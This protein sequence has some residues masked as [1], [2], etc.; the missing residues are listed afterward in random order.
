MSTTFAILQGAAFQGTGLRESFRLLD[1][2]PAWVLV[3]VVLPGLAA[4][5]YLGYRREPLSRGMRTT[6]A[7]LRFLAMALLLAVIF[8]PVKVIRREEVQS[9]EVLVLLLG[10]ALT[11]VP[12]QAL[13]LVIGVL[14]MMFGLRWLRKAILRAA[15]FTQ[16]SC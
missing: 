8:R 11:Q 10:P 16:I 14:L 5:A 1:L 7:V 4:L 6:L 3:L 13:Q 2:P 12:L 9:A 15:G